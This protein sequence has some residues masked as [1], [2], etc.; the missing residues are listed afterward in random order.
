MA[1]F[2]KTVDGNTAAA[3][4]AYAFTDVA[5]IY[6]ITP[7]ST[8]AEVVDEWAAQG[9]KN[10]F[11]QKVS[12]VE[13]QSEAGAAGAFHGSLQAGALTSTFTASQG[14][15]LMIPNMYKVAGELLPGVFHVSARALASQALSIFGDHQDVM[16]ARQTGCVLLASGSVQEVADIAPVAHLAAIE[17]R[18]P[19]I[20]FFDGFRTSHEIQKVELL[21]NE[22][23]AKLLNMEAVQEFRNRALSPNHPVTRGTAQNPDIYFQTREA[24]N[25]YYNDIVGIVDKYMNQMSE[26]TGRKH[27]LFDYYGAEDA[28]YVIVA[29]GSVTE[30]IEETIDVLNAQGEKYGLVKVHL[31]RPFS[32]QH[33]VD[34]MPSTVERICVLDRTK[35]PGA[36]G[37]PLYLDV[38]SVYYGKENAPM[39]IGGRYGLGSKDTVPTHIKTVYDN[40][41]L[42]NPKDQFTLGIVDDVTNTSLELS[43]ELKIA[44]KGT[45]RCKFWG[46]GSDGTVGANKQAIKIIGD[47]T[48]KYAQ[49][50][51]AYDSKKSGGITMSHLRFGDAPIRSTYLIDEA[52][53]IACH[54]QSYV[55]QYDLLKGL[56][57]GG[58]FVLNTIWNEDELNEHLPAAM[59]NYMAKNDIQFYTV[60]GTK[61]GQEIGLGNRI[62]MIMQSAFFKLAQIIPEADAVEYLK[63]SIKKAY[64][65]KGEKIVNMNYKAVDAGMNALVKVN[66]P[67]NWADAKDAVKEEVN[68]PAFVKDIVRPM[69]AQEGD[70]L[71]VSTFNGIEDGT[72][73]AGLAAYEKRGV[74][75][76]VPEWIVDNCIQCNQCAYICPHACIRP[77]LVNEEEMKNA[78]EKFDTKK[79]IGKGFEGLQYR[80]Q[81]SP[82][83]CT[84][85]G[86]CADVC[87]AKEKALV[88]KPLDTQEVEVE[89]WAFAVDT[90]KVAPKGDIMAPTTVKGSQFRQPLM[91]F[92]GACAGC[93]ETPYLKLVTQLFGDRMMIANA[94]G[95]SS[96]WG[97]SAPSTPYTVNHE[98]K[99]PSW[100]NSL[101]EDNAEYGFGMFL[102]VKQMRAKL[103]ETMEQLISMDICDAARTAFTNWLENREDSE[104]SAKAAEEVLAVIAN[105]H[106]IENAEIK[107]LVAEIE[108]R[109]DYLAKRSQW[110]LGGDGWAYD[111]GYGGLDHVLASGENVNVLV[112][113]TEIYSN[114]GG[115]ASKS[116]PIAAMAKFAAAGK[117]SKKKDLGMMAMS[118][119]NVYV[120]QVGMGADKNQLIKAVV[121][122]EKYDGPSLIIAYS[123][124]ISHGLKEG[125]GRAQANIEQA[126]KCGYWHLYR[127]NP[128]LKAEGKNPFT[129]DSKEPTESFRDFLMKQVRYSAIA[130]Q[131]P[132]VADELFEM[133]EENAKDRYE[134]YKRLAE[135]N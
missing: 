68:E 85:C 40:L 36:T 13:M 124:C 53:Y 119:G 55:Y 109:K 130:K 84:G 129:L 113:D 66:I 77:V 127:F 87:P 1:K 76:N 57:K 134:G 104:A 21:E 118:Y 126:V 128:T 69:N 63:D 91:E 88:M 43:D 132:D 103:V 38:K 47:N 20:H 62:N 78:P 64:G 115:Q 82:M 29:M 72:F 6:P 83:D 51:F 49:A 16:A 100:A 93:G 110:I 44:Q 34:A 59:K 65:K 92:S 98:G 133:A 12:V 97:G 105:A 79:A 135:Q 75:V 19:F 46:L 120:A 28:K 9:R 111:I 81:V 14:L 31:Y 8:M 102:G 45:V 4:V 122:A 30:A 17:G 37:E 70:N 123:P 80:M 56:K 33:F 27:G 60:N 10:V 11:G 32:M 61:L 114:T 3:H 2:M 24:S 35:E 117:R 71:P 23:Y 48:E 112:F 54:N 18:L 108:A 42:E 95:C 7:S 22:D 89:N 99:G 73:P 50:Y 41:K 15:L 74:A 106:N 67:A 131:F 25:K 52:D 107:A 39:I 90:K 58:I 86:N 5:A 121:E 94:T 125:M 101:F 96:I 116:T 26:L